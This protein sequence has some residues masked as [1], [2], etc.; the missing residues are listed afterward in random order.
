MWLHRVVWTNTRNK[1]FQAATHSFPF[2]KTHWRYGLI[3]KTWKKWHKMYGYS[4]FILF[5]GWICYLFWRDSPC[6]LVF[7]YRNV[8]LVPAL[9]FKHQVKFYLFLFGVFCFLANITNSSGTGASI[10]IH[11]LRKHCVIVEINVT[12]QD[13]LVPQLYLVC[14]IWFSHCLIF[15]NRA[16][17]A[18]YYNTLAV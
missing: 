5:T 16:I 6:P 10:C 7:V 4:S 17:N 2:F 8:S 12:R 9:L 11:L 13:H 15:K 1:P 3:P 14:P 18:N